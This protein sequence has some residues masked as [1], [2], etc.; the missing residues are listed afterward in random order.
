MNGNQVVVTFNSQLN[1]LFQSKLLQ[2]EKN[3]QFEIKIM[4]VFQKSIIFFSERLIPFKEKVLLSSQESHMIQKAGRFSQ[5]VP[6]YA[7][8][9][10]DL[11]P[12]QRYWQSLLVLL[13]AVI[14]R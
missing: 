7:D 10:P 1:D 9:D 13:V 14:G 4:I 6:T 8:T 3:H 5:M 12:Q 2:E 11:D